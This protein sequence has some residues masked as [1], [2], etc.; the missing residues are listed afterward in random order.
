MADIGEGKGVFMSMVFKTNE[1]WAA[2]LAVF[3]AAFY[4]FSALYG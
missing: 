3:L 4:E 1:L 2:R